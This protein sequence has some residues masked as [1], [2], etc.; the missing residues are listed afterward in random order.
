[1]HVNRGKTL[2]IFFS[3]Q[4]HTLV[5]G[6]AGLFCYLLIIAFNVFFLKILLIKKFFF[7]ARLPA[8]P[9]KRAGVCNT[10]LLERR[11]SAP[12]RPRQIMVVKNNFSGRSFPQNNKKFQP[13]GQTCVKRKMPLFLQLEATYFFFPSLP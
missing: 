3:F 2:A 12:P 4:V 13:P 5:L 11:P 7:F 8:V 1:M 9:G 6:K 10:I